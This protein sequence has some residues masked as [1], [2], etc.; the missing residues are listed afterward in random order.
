MRGVDGVRNGDDDAEQERP[1][2][3]QLQ[4]LQMESVNDGVDC[5]VPAP[6][7]NS[8]IVGNARSRSVTSAPEKA[9]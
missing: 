2:N 9:Q 5:D 3:A 6:L 1:T 4:V 7:H 8:D